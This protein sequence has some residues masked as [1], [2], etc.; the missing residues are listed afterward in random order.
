MPRRTRTLRFIYLT[1]EYSVEIPEHW[2][3]DCLPEICAFR[4][5]L[6]HGDVFEFVNDVGIPT[7]IATG[8]S[9]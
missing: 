1:K 6:R 5:G 7:L 4:I 3:E 8:R 2:P 9:V